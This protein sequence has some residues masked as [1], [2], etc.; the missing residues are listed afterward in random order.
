VERTEPGALASRTTEAAL[1]DGTA[2][3]GLG[4]LRRLLLDILPLNLRLAAADEASRLRL[5]AEADHQAGHAA[6]DRLAE[7]LDTTARFR[8]ATEDEDP[9]MRAVAAIAEAMGAA[10]VPLPR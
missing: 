7:P 6:F 10:L 5:R 1:R 2:W 9:L 8:P 3:P 4:A